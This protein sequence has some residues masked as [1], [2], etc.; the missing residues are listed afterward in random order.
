MG[1]PQRK[2][3]TKL[4]RTGRAQDKTAHPPELF[5]THRGR[6]ALRA[7]PP[8]KTAAA[9][10]AKRHSLFLVQVILPPLLV[11][12]HDPAARGFRM[13]Y[14]DRF[15]PNLTQSLQPDL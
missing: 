10:R 5:E 14:I 6:R 15:G 8:P 9:T 3:V 4:F 12:A 1:L 2:N 13:Y 7:R 11:P